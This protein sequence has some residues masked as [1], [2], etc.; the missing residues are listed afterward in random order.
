[1][2]CR[3]PAPRH[4]NT[5]QYTLPAALGTGLREEAGTAVGG[6]ANGASVYR[7]KAGASSPYQRSTSE[8]SRWP[9]RSRRPGARSSTKHVWPT[10]TDL[11]ASL[12]PSPPHRGWDPHE[13]PRQRSGGR[14]PVRGVARTASARSRHRTCPFASGFAAVPADTMGRGTTTGGAPRATPGLVH[15][16]GALAMGT[17]AASWGITLIPSR[18]GTP[19]VALVGLVAAGP[20][21]DGGRCVPGGRVFPDRTGAPRWQAARTYRAPWVARGHGAPLPAGHLN[22]TPGDVRRAGSLGCDGWPSLRLSA[23]APARVRRYLPRSLSMNY[24]LG[25]P[26]QKEFVW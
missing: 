18:I 4:R 12:G 19:W 10:G 13:P 11:S 21:G 20:G 5:F 8:G 3:T 2:A 23:D 7:R 25:T 14:H 1:M 22:V 26:E 15:G 9:Y 6:P 17:V 16:E 24:W